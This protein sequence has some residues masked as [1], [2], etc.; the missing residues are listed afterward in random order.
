MLIDRRDLLLGAGAFALTSSLPARGQAGDASAEAVLAEV[1]E[2]LLA[3]YP[4]N[5]TILGLD[6]GARAGLKSRLA[7]RSAAGQ[8]AI[9]RRAGER[10]ARLRAIDPARLGPAARIDVDVVRTAHET[11]L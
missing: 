3:D 2:A 4:E 6:H 7:D 5:A 11:A 9:A 1:A 10:L 8:Q